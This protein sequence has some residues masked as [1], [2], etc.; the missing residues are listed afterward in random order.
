MDGERRTEIR[1]WAEGLERSDV[2]EVRAAGRALSLLV[3]ENE[4]L[5]RRLERLEP[6]GPAGPPPDATDAPPG[7]GGKRG[8]RARKAF[9]WRL[10]SVVAAVVAVAAVVTAL[11]MAAVRPN[12]KAGGAEDG[13]TLGPAA[14]A[15][16]TFW[17]GGE[18]QAEAEWRLD[19]RKVAPRRDG[20]R[21]VFR[22]GKLAD[23]KHLLE[24][25]VGGPLFTSTTRQIAFA[26]DTAAP[27]LRLDSPAAHRV[28]EPIRIA[29]RVE[30]SARLSR[31]GH[32]VPLAD[33]GAFRLELPTRPPRGMLVLEA[34]DRA[35]NRS[36]WQVPISVI[37][38]Q[39]VQ[40]V[41]SV[42]VT[43]H[44]WADPSLRKGVLALVEA[45]KVNAVE[46]DLKDESGLIG[47][48]AP[49]PYAK[50]IGAVE[51]VFDLERA[52]EEL[53]AKGVR[54]IGRLVC[55]R[56]PI[57]AQA[58]WRGGRRDEVVQTPDG[59]A[60]SGYGGFT[61]FAS[62]AVRQYNIDVA[63]AAAKG[64][65]DEIL[66]DYVRRPDGPI[67]SMRFPGLRGTTERAIV[68]F[69]E[70]SRDALAS[71]EA[72]VGA[73]VFGVA[74]T[75]PEEVAQD[76]PA[77]ARTVDYIAP[78]VY[79]S[80]WGP[81][82]YSVANPNGEPYT[83]T[84]RALADFARK[85][86]STGAR[87]VPWL[88]DF[89]LGWDYG[90]AEVAAQIRAAR[91]AGMD[92]FILWDPAVTY[93]SDALEPT[94]KR[95]ALE[96]KTT[97]PEG[98]P[99]PKRLPD[100]KQATGPP[101]TAKGPGSGLPPNELG[102]VPVLM[103]HEIRPDRVGAFDQTPAEFRAELEHLWKL[104]YAPVNASDFADGRIDLPAGKSPVVLTFD[105]AT[106]FQLELGRDGAPKKNTAVSI[107]L[108][109]ARTHP[110][111]AP[112]ATFFLLREPFGGTARSA[113]HVRWLVE[114]GF[115]L[116]NHSHDHT[117]LGTLGDAEVQ[118]Q[119]VRGARVILDAV[120]GY[121]IRSLALP[122]GSM[123]ERAELAVRGRSGGQRYGPYAV[124]LVGA[125][126]APSPY[127]R[128][129]DRTEI[130]RIRSSHMPWSSAEE[131]TFA[132]WMRK[133]GRNPELRFVSD[134]DPR[135]ITVPHAQRDSVAR[136]FQSRVRV[137]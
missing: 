126:P 54:V 30:P 74:A 102:V 14:L 76:I 4:E 108:D 40:P 94:A 16:L 133:L 77:M 110:G 35:G 120:P 100:P 73:S 55:F 66:Y 89:S 69:L 15:R 104:G 82:E 9:P 118:R 83:I 96:L 42:H 2:A 18:G 29:G 41:R 44:A 34:A 25:S 17:A 56:D 122:L 46:I 84:R 105:D 135:T 45:N 22:P 63:V 123:P 3:D 65:V 1:R 20:E 80:H 87:V 7:R 106:I 52:V 130:P 24:I 92:E 95:P 128:D 134:G 119:L 60:Y 86:R 71:T 21:L 26:V 47:W 78:M 111:F 13:A 68:E 113:E 64:G 6:R 97:P 53:H 23:G 50:R 116:G 57:H 58:A 115:E 61:N 33:D 124:F 107:L 125:N 70:Q 88:Q 75:R 12:L 8:P 129:F 49:V 101:S 85:T 19:G 59:Q 127:S 91:D 137:S 31:A 114:N 28:G 10:V 32:E 103:Y 99:G 132:D 98:L 79:P 48:D 136:R 43:A 131:Y 121:R 117:P 27:L 11:A 67:S 112:K 109:F 37:P 93:T 5:T 38:R 62:P 51:E 81:G 72:L 36:R 39:P 90:P